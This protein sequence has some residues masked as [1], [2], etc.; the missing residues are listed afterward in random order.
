MYDVQY[1][2]P[3]HRNHSTNHFWPA[4]LSNQ[5]TLYLRLNCDG[6]SITAPDFEKFL[7]TTSDGSTDTVF[8]NTT[9]F[10]GPFLSKGRVQELPPSIGP[11][12]ARQVA[13]DVVTAII[14]TGYKSSYILKLLQKSPDTPKNTDMCEET[15]KAK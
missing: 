1:V 3:N 12:P 6:V 14:N 11:G 5:N 13:K 8:F 15:I 2:M 9:C 4:F 10:T 7:F